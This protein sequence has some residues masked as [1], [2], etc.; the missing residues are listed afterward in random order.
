MNVIYHYDAGPWL[1]GRLIELA[2][3]HGLTVTTCREDDDAGFAALLPAAEVLLHNL[4]PVTEAHM[5]AAPRLRLIQKIGLCVHTLDLDAAQ[6]PGIDVCHLPGPHHPA[7]TDLS[8][9]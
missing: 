4:C 8:P 7:G 9:P 6:R 3:R 5:A 1:S 2:T